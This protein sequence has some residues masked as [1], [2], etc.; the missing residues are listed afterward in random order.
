MQSSIHRTIESSYSLDVAGKKTV[1]FVLDCI[2]SQRQ[3]CNGRELNILDIGCGTGQLTKLVGMQKDTKILAIDIDDESLEIAKNSTV[4]MS[5][6]IFAKGSVE[7]F[8]SDEKYDVVLLTQVLDHITDPASLIQKTRGMLK[9]NGQI[10]VGISNGYGIYEFSKDVFPKLR[11]KML[12]NS[13][14]VKMLKQLPFT[15]NHK[16]PH[17]HKYSLSKLKNMLNDC[18]FEVNKLKKMTFVL[19]AFPIS[20][21]FYLTPERIASAVETIDYALAKVLP[22]SLSSNWYISCVPLKSRK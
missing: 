20:L 9:D 15:C 12:L 10:I 19:P 8:V 13:K 16:S 5:N 1:E 22:G 4:G 18:G 2:D 6:I 11:K 21:L 14:R 3:K 7:E 17:I